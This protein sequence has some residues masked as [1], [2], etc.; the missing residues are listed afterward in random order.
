MPWAPTRMPIERD[1][2]DNEVSCGLL[3]ISTT[4]RYPTV[5]LQQNGRGGG[6]CKEG[7]KGYHEV[8]V[9]WVLLVEIWARGMRFML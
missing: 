6:T 7:A 4:L 2:S 1:P 8:Y 9:H 3:G 5:D